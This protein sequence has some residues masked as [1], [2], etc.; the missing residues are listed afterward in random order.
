M[1]YKIKGED[2]FTISA[3]TKLL[4]P[5]KDGLVKAIKCAVSRAAKQSGLQR[6]ETFAWFHGDGLNTNVSR[7]F[8]V[9]VCRPLTEEERHHI[10]EQFKEMCSK[11]HWGNPELFFR[12]GIH[13]ANQNNE[14]STAYL[15]NHSKRRFV[16]V[17]AEGGG[18]QE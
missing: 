14:Y 8:H 5:I 12:W 2:C 3:A 7:S 6:P 10:S 17:S 18:A 1:L 15:E 11:E 4:H 13:L 16:K 9:A